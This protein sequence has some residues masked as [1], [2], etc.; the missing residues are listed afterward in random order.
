MDIQVKKEIKILKD[1]GIFL[2]KNNIKATEKLL[3][4][5]LNRLDEITFNMNE[6]NKDYQLMEKI[7]HQ[8]GLLIDELQNELVKKN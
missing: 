6:R 3:K 5:I 7:I 4:K 1:L 2:K 8:Q